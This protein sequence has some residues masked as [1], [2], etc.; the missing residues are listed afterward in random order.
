[1]AALDLGAVG[2]ARAGDERRRLLLDPAEGGDVVVR[3]EQD[4]G[5]A[6]AGLRREVGLPLG[7]AVAAVRE[8]ARHR[9]GV[10]VAHRPLQ[11][12]QRE[13]VD[14]EED[15]ARGVRD[16]PL[17][18][19]PGD[20]LDH[21]ERVRVVVVRPEDHV[22]HDAN[23]RRDERDPERRPEGVDREVAV[24]DRVRR[25][26]HQRVEHEHEHEPDEQHQRQPQRRDERGQHRVQDR[27]HRRGEESAPEVVTLAPGTIQAATS[28]A[29]AEA[30][31]ATSS[32]AGT[33]FGRAGLQS[34][35]VL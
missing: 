7:E 1:M 33:S 23:R 13:P 17:A 32:R 16:R 11:H 15:D 24:G 2:R 27:D 6:R 9:R 21:P 25:E 28:S 18:R 5:L 4:P 3:A 14:L 19:A 10:A 8:P 30:S 12:G 26:Q 31:Q 22:E 34:G 29:S 20:P 35:E